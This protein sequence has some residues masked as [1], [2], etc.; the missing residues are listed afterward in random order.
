M[1]QEEK[2]AALTRQLTKAKFLLSTKHRDEELVQ[3]QQDDG[4]QVAGG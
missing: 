1:S 3:G 2:I 4:A